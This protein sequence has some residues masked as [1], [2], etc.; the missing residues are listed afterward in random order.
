MLQFCL[1]VQWCGVH[2]PHHPLLCPL[3]SRQ[4]LRDRND[5]HRGRGRNMPMP[6]KEYD[7]SFLEWKVHPCWRSQRLRQHCIRLI[8]DYTDTVHA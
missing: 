3:Q 8:V 7:V 1:D 5:L 2:H 6:P 4:I